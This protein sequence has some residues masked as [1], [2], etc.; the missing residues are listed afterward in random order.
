MVLTF[1]TILISLQSLEVMASQTS[2]TS[3]KIVPLEAGPYKHP[4]NQI[5]TNNVLHSVNGER[6]GVSER[7]DTTVLIPLAYQYYK[8]VFTEASGADIWLALQEIEFFPAPTYSKG[9]FGKVD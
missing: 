2:I 8:L 7:P 6:D 9:K 3:L 4:P 1:V 5:Q